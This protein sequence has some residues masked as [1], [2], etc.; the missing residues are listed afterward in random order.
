MSLTDSPQLFS[1]S[2]LRL[3][4]FPTTGPVPALTPCLV[5]SVFSVTFI[6]FQEAVSGFLKEPRIVTGEM[7]TLWKE[8]YCE[9]KGRILV[10][11]QNI[12]AGCIVLEDQCMLG[13]QSLGCLNRT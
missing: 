13:D 9:G 10:A 7:A 2:Q 4:T 1:F 12:S 11:S 3:M 6:I 8:S 5:T